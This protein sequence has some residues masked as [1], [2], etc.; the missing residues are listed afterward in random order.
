LETLDFD[1]IKFT[2]YAF[3]IEMKFAAWRSGFTIREVPIIF[4]DRS[5]G[6]SKMSGSIFGE[7]VFGVLWMKLKSF[8]SN[9]KK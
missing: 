7:A 2:G 8:F 1:K 5:E 3:Q 4:T 9:Y 6:Q